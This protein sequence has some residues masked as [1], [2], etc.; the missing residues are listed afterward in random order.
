MRVHN[1]WAGDWAVLVT[2]FGW[3]LLVGRI[4]RMLFPIGLAGLVAHLGQSTGLVAGEAVV[5]LVIGTFLS[6]KAY[7]RS[8][9]AKIFSVP[10]AVTSPAPPLHYA[11]LTAQRR[12]R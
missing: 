5:L 2:I 8:S 9:E 11:F 7:M 6:Y 10:A 12:Y 3:L 4:A 1:H